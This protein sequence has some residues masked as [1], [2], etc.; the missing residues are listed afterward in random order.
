VNFNSALETTK[1]TK[2]AIRKAHKL[3]RIERKKREKLEAPEKASHDGPESA[4]IPDQGTDGSSDET[5]PI[6]KQTETSVFP[7]IPQP[8]AAVVPVPT[9][10]P[11]ETTRDR[12]ATP[13]VLNGLPHRP[14][15]SEPFFKEVPAIGTESAPAAEAKQEVKTETTGSVLPTIDDPDAVALKAEKAKKRQNAL[16]RTLWSL[17][18]IGGFIGMFFS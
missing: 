1:L 2:S 9:K 4:V 5:T 7:E 17:V 11:T 8:V 12:S 15:P 16:T 10:V 3:A 18:M 14:P 13:M 6:E